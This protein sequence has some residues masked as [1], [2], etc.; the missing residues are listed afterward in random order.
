MHLRYDRLRYI[1][2]DIGNSGIKACELFIG[3]QSLGEVWYTR[4][5]FSTSAHQLT[6]SESNPSTK[7][8]VDDP[9]WAEA[10]VANFGRDDTKWLISS[11]RRDALQSLKSKLETHRQSLHIVCLHDIPLRVEVDAPNLVGIDRLLAAVA[12]SRRCEQRPLIVIQVG[13]AVTVD[14]L[15]RQEKK[16]T[17]CGGAILPGVPMMLRLLGQA[18]DLLPNIDADDITDLPGIPG[19]NT[20]DAMLAGCASATLG[21]TI[22]L[23]NRYRNE[24]GCNTPI[25]ISGGDGDRFAPHLPPP[26]V[27]VP[28]LVH[29]GLA[30]VAQ[31]MQEE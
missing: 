14:F 8:A 13:S 11:V 27:V 2:I 3:S 19:R 6:F 21:G 18:A 28:H 12:A 16:D 9:S 22:H 17:F 4:W 20:T 31:A 15:A 25:V 5:L 7:V 1:G 24:F 30:A 10:L 23:I 29:H 26:Y